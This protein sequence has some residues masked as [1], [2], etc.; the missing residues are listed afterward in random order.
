MTEKATRY[1]CRFGLA[2]C[3]NTVDHYSRIRVEFYQMQHIEEIL[4]E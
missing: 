3:L 4:A 2:F 1:S